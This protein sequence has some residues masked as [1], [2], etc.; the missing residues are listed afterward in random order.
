MKPLEMC[1]IC[2]Y[3][4]GADCCPECGASFSE[5][6][7]R[8]LLRH[9]ASTEGR[10]L[11]WVVRMLIIA[12]LLALISIALFLAFLVSSMLIDW[13]QLA[14]AGFLI[15]AF[16]AVLSALIWFVGGWML[17]RFA[18]T[19]EW[20]ASQ[21]TRWATGL[22]CASI[23]GWLAFIGGGPGLLVSALACF[24]VAGIGSTIWNQVNICSTIWG[25]TRRARYV[26]GVRRRPPTLAPRVF[27][28]VVAAWVGLVITNIILGLVPGL[29]QEVAKAV[30]A[31]HALGGV[32]PV[33]LI[34]MTLIAA[35]Q[36][37]RDIRN[38]LSMQGGSRH[39]STQVDGTQH[40]ELRRV[41]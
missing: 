17:T 10:Q 8:G 22:T 15:V 32:L 29:G 41:S 28:G 30:N 36:L 39:D 16:G 1:A 26:Q 7:D 34:T 24:V 25:M 20:K 37:S 33:I 2:G 18:F 9:V 21:Y 35:D 40:R 19:R 13:P 31:M 14:D 11:L 12:P 5:A 23:A 4:V 27:K 6:Q 38:E 3:P